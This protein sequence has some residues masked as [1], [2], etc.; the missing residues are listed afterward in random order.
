MIRMMRMKQNQKKNQKKSKHKMSQS[1]SKV[2]GL[3]VELVE[4]KQ[5][6][7]HDG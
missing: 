7:H 2:S 4:K 5:V 1:T 6:S 3:R